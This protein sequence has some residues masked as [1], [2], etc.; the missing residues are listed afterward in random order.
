M[1]LHFPKSFSFMK[2]R[3]LSEKCFRK[4]SFLVVVYLSIRWSV[5][6]YK[7]R[8][9]IHLSYKALLGKFALKSVGSAWEFYIWHVQSV[10]TIR[11]RQYNTR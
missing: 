5:S 3:T 8:F 1:T 6:L 7:F 4:I 11:T 9:Q 2:R 10:H